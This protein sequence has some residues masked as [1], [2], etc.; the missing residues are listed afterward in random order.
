M[1]NHVMV[2]DKSKSNNGLRRLLRFVVLGLLLGVV[3]HGCAKDPYSRRRIS[4]RTEHFKLTLDGIRRHEREGS[5]R[6][7]TRR[8][9]LD[10]WWEASKAEYKMRCEQAGDYIW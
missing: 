6:L 2:I 7:R 8:V 1:F 5:D 4:R 10:R 3:V 9:E